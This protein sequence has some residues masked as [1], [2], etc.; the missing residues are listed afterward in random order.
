MSDDL[1]ANLRSLSR[2][3]HADLSIADEAAD[4]IERLRAEN[5]K[6]R[7]ALAREDD[8]IRTLSRRSYSLDALK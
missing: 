4:E 5:V 1:V 7:E 8:R 6:L 3:E 2:Y